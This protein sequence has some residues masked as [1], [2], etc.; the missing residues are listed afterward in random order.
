MP[1]KK[2][3]RRDNCRRIADVRV[4]AKRAAPLSDDEAQDANY[5][6]SGGTSSESAHRC[7]TADPSR[8]KARLAQQAKR[9]RRSARATA[10][11]PGTARLAWSAVLIYL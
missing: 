10:A 3:G 1:P 11:A 4:R 8:E 2:D 9:A 7:M 6:S 5:M